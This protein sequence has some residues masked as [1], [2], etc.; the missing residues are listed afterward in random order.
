MSRFVRPFFLALALCLTAA[1]APLLSGCSA[2]GQQAPQSP[3]DSLRYS[4][5]T[6]TGIYRTIGDLT[7]AK[8]VTPAEASRY[9]KQANALEGDLNTAELVVTGIKPGDKLTA[10]S[11]L[12]VT[13][14]SLLALAAELRA[15]QPAA[16]K[17]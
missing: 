9:L 7:A 4:Q 2:L 8:T 6:L 17:P 16:P 10:L 12:N 14:T 3:E 11:L 1:A 15:R 5:A 13:R